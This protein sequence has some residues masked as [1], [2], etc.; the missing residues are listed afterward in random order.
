M[1][2]QIPGLEKLADKHLVSAEQAGY[3]ELDG[4]KKDA[5][6]DIVNVEGGVSSERGCCN[7]FDPEKGVKRFNCGSCEHVSRK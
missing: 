6:C 2:K 3:M 7:L 1:S 4:A 5:S